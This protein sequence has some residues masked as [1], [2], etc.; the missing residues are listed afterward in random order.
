MQNSSRKVHNATRIAGIL[1]IS[2]FLILL[3][4]LILLITNGAFTAFAEGL[5]GSLAAK[6]PYAAL[7]RQLNFL[8][9]VGWV[10]QLM[11]FGL[12]AWLLLRAEDESLAIPAFIAILVA[13]ILGVIHG[14]FHMT[15]ETWAAEE[16]ARTGTIPQVYHPISL[17]ISD[18]FR[19]A[20]ILQLLGTVGFGWSILRVELLAPW[21]GLVSI[22]WGIFWLFAY[23]AG[24]G[25]PGLLFILPAMIGVALLRKRRVGNVQ[26]A[27]SELG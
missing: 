17:W 22:G 8:W 9:T 18:T 12:L 27:S 14:T 10:I 2:S 19:I 6:A 21:V 4:A 20:Y 3:L 13:A 24:A 1:L 15:V 11:G 7:F 5:R 26:T 16:A 25:A 23:L